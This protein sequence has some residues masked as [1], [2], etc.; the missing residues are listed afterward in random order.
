[1]CF[2]GRKKYDVED[3][4][5]MREVLDILEDSDLDFSDS[6]DEN[7]DIWLPK[8]H[9]CEESDDGESDF[10]DFCKLLTFY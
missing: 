6:D 2:Q 4:C 1:M 7:D 8:N 3:P 10:F 5:D 9:I